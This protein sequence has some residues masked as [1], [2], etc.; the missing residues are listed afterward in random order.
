MRVNVSSV[1]NGFQKFEKVARVCCSK[2]FPRL[3]PCRAGAGHV[4]TSKAV[5]LLSKDTKVEESDCVRGPTEHLSIHGQPDDW[6]R[7]RDVQMRPSAGLV[8]C[9]LGLSTTRSGP[10]GPMSLYPDASTAKRNA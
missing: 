1:L 6:T 9:R 10:D 8:Q 3:G 7:L 2:R 4:A 5:E